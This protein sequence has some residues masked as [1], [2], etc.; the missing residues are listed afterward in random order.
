MLGTPSVEEEVPLAVGPLLWECPTAWLTAPPWMSTT[1]LL[2]HP[3][4]YNVVTTKQIHTKTLSGRPLH[5]VHVV[6]ESES[7]IG[8]G[9][10]ACGLSRVSGIERA[11][12]DAA[13]RP[14]FVGSVPVLAMAIVAAGSR[15]D[16]TA[17]TRF[18]RKA[19]SFRTEMDSGQCVALL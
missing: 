18:P 4:L 10:I 6:H 11:L 16:V 3:G 12:L 13:M 5:I 7:R 9:A 1:L 8:V 15:V 17:L 14:N 19:P 2:I